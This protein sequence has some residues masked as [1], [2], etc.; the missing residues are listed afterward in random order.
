MSEQLQVGKQDINTILIR[1]AVNTQN[2]TQKSK[3]I[4]MIL[5]RTDDK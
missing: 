4:Q 3:W 1:L 2:N 5:L